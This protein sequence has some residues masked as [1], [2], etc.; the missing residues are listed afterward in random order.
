[1]IDVSDGLVAD[2][3][4]VAAESRVSI[5]IRSARLA[6]ERLATAAAT[7]RADWREW[8]LS[9]GEDHVL[10]ASFPSDA[11]VPQAWTIVGQIREG[12]GVLVDSR[13]WDG[14]GGWDH[15]RPR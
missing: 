11:H 10:A 2:L 9:G 4:H 13:P 3:G 12:N 6:D 8:A 15:F 5:D 14:R 1:M 7:L